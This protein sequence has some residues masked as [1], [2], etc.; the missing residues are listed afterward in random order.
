VA[1]RSSGTPSTFQ[2]LLIPGS[3]RQGG[4]TIML[5]VSSFDTTQL[6]ASALV[7]DYGRAFHAVAQPWHIS[8][9]RTHRFR[10][11]VL[12]RHR[13]TR[14][15]PDR[16]EICGRAE[17]ALRRYNAIPLYLPLALESPTA[18]FCFF[19]T[20]LWSQPAR[21]S[22]MD[23]LDHSRAGQCRALQPYCPQHALTAHAGTP[24]SAKLAGAL[25]IAL[26]FG[27][28]AF[29][30]MNVEGV[31]KASVAAKSTIV[32]DDSRGQ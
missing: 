21:I 12:R 22:Y 27:D 23:H 26:W 2:A 7:A 3:A 13:A 6:S 29:S 11:R 5:D 30:A 31:P 32:V 10:G 16:C 28:M 24:L 9:E 25:S 15:A 20:R 19:M 17:S 1:A 8:C 18:F 14:F 4:D